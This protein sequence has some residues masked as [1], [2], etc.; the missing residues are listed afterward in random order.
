MALD[1][2]KR[3]HGLLTGGGGRRVRVREAQYISPTCAS[4][5]LT[6][7]GAGRQRG[8]PTNL[9]LL[10][11]W[12]GWRQQEPEHA[13]TH[14]L[15]TPSSS[16]LTS[17]REPYLPLGM[18]TNGVP[19]QLWQGGCVAGRGVIR[20]QQRRRALPELQ[21]PCSASVHQSQSCISTRPRV[22]HGSTRK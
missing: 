3:R 21:L 2:Y 6:G 18:D 15:A 8:L 19:A 10:D 17:N 9:T 5:H 22:S 12:P 4:L 14:A 11:P 13:H 1:R 16:S 7:A 20:T